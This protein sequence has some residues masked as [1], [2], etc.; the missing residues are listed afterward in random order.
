VSGPSSF[1]ED[2]DGELYIVS[3]SAGAVYK[4]RG[5]SAVNRPP[6]VT[7]PGDQTNDEGHA[8]ALSISANDPDGDTLVYD[9]TGLPPALS[10]DR[11]SGLISGTLSAGSAGSYNAVVSVD[12]GNGNNDSTSFTW[13]VNEPPP[14][15]VALTPGMMDTGAYGNRYGSDQHETELVATFMYTGD[16]YVL[17]VTGY[18]IDYVDE[19]AVYL[20]GALLGHLS[21]GPNNGLNTGDSFAIPA[22]QQLTG[23]NQILFQERTAGW[24][25]GVT[26]LLLTN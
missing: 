7:S 18:D 5:Q 14:A 24:I 6:T 12:D 3:L 11:D 4:I 26:D 8:V 16:D 19:V 1:G 22:A 20:N 15:T 23:Q 9:A 2:V 17:N 10:I 13:L 25:W 21:K